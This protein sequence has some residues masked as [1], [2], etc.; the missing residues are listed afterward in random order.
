MYEED[1][2]DEVDTCDKREIPYN[3][4][5]GQFIGHVGMFLLF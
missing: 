5:I 1:P 3:I 2:G 4:I